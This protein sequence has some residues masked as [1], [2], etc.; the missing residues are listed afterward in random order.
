[1]EL[2]EDLKIGHRRFQN[3]EGSQGTFGKA[4]YCPSQGS[5]VIVYAPPP[6]DIEKLA[7][8][9]E[10]PGLWN[11]SAPIH[12]RGDLARKKKGTCTKAQMERILRRPRRGPPAMRGRREGGNFTC[13]SC[14]LRDRLRRMVL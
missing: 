11:A 9:F 2:L 7:L 4:V 1:M 8:F 12:A 5:A 10:H 13:P 14:L 6:I 3:P